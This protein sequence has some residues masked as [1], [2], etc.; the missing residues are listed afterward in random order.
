MQNE[1]IEIRKDSTKTPL[2]PHCEKE[3]R[4]LNTR[5]IKS[6]VGVRFLYFEAVPDGLATYH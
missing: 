1:P 5:K 2:C 3:I 4:V 6:P